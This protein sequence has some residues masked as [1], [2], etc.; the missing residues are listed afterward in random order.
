MQSAKPHPLTSL[1]FATLARKAAVI[2]SQPN[3]EA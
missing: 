1:N 2:A 3:C